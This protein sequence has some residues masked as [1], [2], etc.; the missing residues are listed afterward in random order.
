[1]RFLANEQNG[2]TKIFDMTSRKTPTQVLNDKNVHNNSRFFSK[3]QN[4]LFFRN[5]PSYHMLHQRVKIMNLMYILDICMK[6]N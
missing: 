3:R 1:M 4:I 6:Y 5:I 2:N